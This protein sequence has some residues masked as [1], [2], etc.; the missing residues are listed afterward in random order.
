MSKIACL[1]GYVLSD[2]VVPPPYN[3]G[4]ML[5]HD[6]EHVLYKQI[7]RDVVALIS[8]VQQGDR[9]RWMR[10]HFR[11]DDFSYY[12]N[13]DEILYD[14]LLSLFLDY[15]RAVDQCP[16]CGRLLIQ[17]YPGENRYC[18]FQP[19]GEWQHVLTN[20]HSRSDPNGE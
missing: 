6:D 9:D 14:Y 12:H 8:A 5:T 4:V 17:K 11:G 7:A 19:E 2:S 15:I 16:Q 18:F 10:Q 20:M 1:C 13:L 3:T